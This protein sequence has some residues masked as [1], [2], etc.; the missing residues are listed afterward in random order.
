VDDF[1]FITIV[2]VPEHKKVWCQAKGCGHTVYRRVHV[3][4][5][6]GQI[7]VFGSDC[8]KRLFGEKLKNAKPVIHQSD[9]IP[10]TDADVELLKNN[11]EELIARLKQEYKDKNTP[12]AANPLD[13]SSMTDDQLEQH[14]LEQVKQ[15]FRKER[16]INPDLPGFAGW[17]KVEAKKL[18]KRIH[19]QLPGKASYTQLMPIFRRSY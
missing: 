12:E 8:A 6:N 14:C 16:G 15:Q 11:T 13:F 5:Q 17:A 19:S 10:L 3:I 18:F 1:E 9:G 4:R 2:E 7:S